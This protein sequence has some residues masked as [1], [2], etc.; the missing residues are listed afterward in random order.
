MTMSRSIISFFIF[1]YHFIHHYFYIISTLI[2]FTGYSIYNTIF[3][4]WPTTSRTITDVR[5]FNNL[6]NHYRRYIKEF[7]KIALL[8]MNLLKGSP[9]RGSTIEW[10][11]NEEAAFQ[12]LKNTVISEPILQHPRMG[13]QF[14]IDPNLL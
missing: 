13:Q 5:G 3:T 12:V 1:R 10:M 8:L 14:I 4:N 2:A 11:E 6:V 7:A 9:I